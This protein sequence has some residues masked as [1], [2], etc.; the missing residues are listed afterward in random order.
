MDRFRALAP[1]SPARLARS[2]DPHPVQCNG[3]VVTPSASPPGPWPPPP[4]GRSPFS[5]HR[6]RR[7]RHPHHRL[8]VAEEGVVEDLAFEGSRLKGLEGVSR[9]GISALRQGINQ[10]ER[11]HRGWEERRRRGS[12]NEGYREILLPP[13]LVPSDP[14]ARPPTQRATLV[15]PSRRDGDGADEP[16]HPLVGTLNFGEVNDR[17]RGDVRQ[18]LP[19]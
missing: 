7:R 16:W 13:P 3:I 12:G 5:R 19:P 9:P 2:N 8:A 1:R 10:R 6:G 11:V 4:S 17:C 18:A 15:I 14:R